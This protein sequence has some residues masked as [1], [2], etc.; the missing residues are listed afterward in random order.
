MASHPLFPLLLDIVHTLGVQ[1][2]QFAS[3]EERELARLLTAAINAHP[4]SILRDLYQLEWMIKRLRE[5]I[6][7]ARIEGRI[8]KEEEDSE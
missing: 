8:V 7:R 1:E 6:E 2:R 5:G 3:Y 4:P